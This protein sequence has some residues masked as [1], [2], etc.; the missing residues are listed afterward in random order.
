MEATRQ[1]SE[2]ALIDAP[3]TH[4]PFRT[5]TVLGAGTMGAQIAA[6]LANSGMDVHLLDIAPQ[7]GGDK[8]AIVAKG[9]NR[10]RE[11]KPDPFFTAD[12]ARRITTGNF[13]DDFDRVAEAEWVIEA[14]VERLDVKRDLIERIE[15]HISPDA[16]VST[17]TSGLSIAD[18]VKGTSNTF[19]RRFL[20]THFFNPPRYLKLL[21]LVPSPDTDESVVQRIA[22][23]GRVHLGKGIVIAK[24]TPYFIGNRIGVYAMLQAMRAVF[25]GDYTIKEIDLLTGPLTGRPKSATFRTADIVGLDVMKD[26]ADNLYDAV[27]D[28]DARQ[29]FRTPEILNRLVE[30]GSLGQKSG[31]GF[32]RKEGKTIKSL[33]PETVDYTEDGEVRLSGIEE[34]FRA[35]DLSARLRALYEDDGRGGRFFK[36]TVLDLLAYSARRV[37]EI[38]DNPADVDRAIRWGFGWE[39]GPFQIW[40]VLGFRKLIED[41]EANALKL[42]AWIRSMY[43][44][45]HNHFYGRENHHHTIYAPAKED[46]VGDPRPLDH[47]SL[48]VIKTSPEGELWSSDAAALLDLG[49]GVA[50]Y[51]FR[52]KAN[53]LGREVMEGLR[54]AVDRVEEDPARRGLVV[55]NEGKNFSVGANLVE[56]A[57][58][59]RDGAG[60]EVG[61]YLAEFQDTI[62]RVRYARKPVVVAVHQ[63]ALGGACELVMACSHPVAA[64][65]SYIG[66]VELGVGL[67]PAG[68]GTTRLAALASERSPNRHPSEIQAWLQRFF[69]TVAMAGVSTSAP[70]AQ[71]L[72]YLASHAHIVMNDRR[73]IHV[74]REEVLRL[75]SQGYIPPPPAKHIT[76][77]GRPTAAAFAISV[78]QYQ[79]GQFISEYDAY[80][81]MRLA[82]IMTGGALDGPNEVHEDYLLELERDVFLDLLQQDKTRERIDHMLKTKKPLRN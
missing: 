23:F 18:I 22:H 42:P 46:Y 39:M 30:R 58:G 76:V 12:A 65:E 72:G 7:K 69:E 43:A 5:A 26:V 62:Q 16:I 32:Y 59:I 61:A 20:G 33:D 41:M 21:E 74:A 54:Y 67:I 78:Q 25:Q 77:L 45:G 38:A 1:L 28:D 79:E 10:A 34:I 31:E 17:N 50:L 15:G 27:P 73:L 47:I 66:L 24:D 4:L 29:A 35:G 9:L 13:D 55:A 14:V 68:T 11:S 51:E 70:D 81:A 37:P 44:S 6:H 52:S 64:A 60:A 53:T 2:A 57:A 48:E 71:R 3:H 40:D 75:S 82:Y 49:D 36:E 8:N 56:M 63:R 80:L 19:R